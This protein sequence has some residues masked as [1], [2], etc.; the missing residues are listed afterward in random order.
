MKLESNIQYLKGVGEKR[1]ALYNKLGIVTV[2]DLLYHFP[3]NY[4][5]LST[6]YSIMSAPLD[7]TCAIIARLI[8]KST[9]KRIRKGLS[10]FKLMAEDYSGSLEITVFNAKYT[11]DSLETDKE[12]IFFGRV[13][14]NMIKR[15]MSA[16]DIYSV[17]DENT[18]L[19]IYS[20]TLGLTSKLI[21][22]NI[23]QALEDLS[24]VKDSLCD[25]ILEKYS[26]LGLSVSLR[27]I[28][29]PEKIEQAHTARERF[30]FE[31]LLVLCCGLAMLSAE[32]NACITKPMKE[33]S[34]E[35]FW[36]NLPFAPTNAQINAVNDAI[37]DMCKATPMNRLVQG[38]VGSGKTLVAA[39]CVYFSY[40]NGVQSAMMAPTSI[41][42]EQ[43]FRTIS[44][45]LSPLGLTTG[46][47]TGSTCAVTQPGTD[48]LSTVSCNKKRIYDGISNGSINFCVGTHALI[49]DGVGFSQLGFIV[50]DEQHRFGV[51]QRT[52]LQKKGRDSHVMVMSATPIPRTLSLIVYGDL[53]LSVIDEMPPGRQEIDTFVISSAKRVRAMGFL[54]NALDEGRQAYIICPLVEMGEVDT[55][56]RP[57]KEY[58]EYL[59]EN[60]FKGYSISLLHGKMNPREKEEVMRKFSNG[61]VQALVS[62]T[63]VEVGVDVPNAT[64]IL[65]EN[66]ERFGLSQLHQ[67]RGRVGRG[68]EKS[69][70]I[71]VSDAKGET[72]RGRL[73]MMKSST[74]GFEL[75]EYDLKAR[76]P[77]DFFGHRQHGLPELKVASLADNMKTMALARECAEDILSADPDLS[78]YDYSPL[79]TMVRRMMDS[80]GERPN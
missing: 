16:P 30:V 40:L 46:L 73:N 13:T 72:A 61:E 14:G 38:D 15:T 26:L 25:D 42:A 56:L 50:T 18:I 41:L 3:R 12:Y 80:V 57:A 51:T 6:P 1:A 8:H 24:D 7:E 67:L 54:R 76:G 71:L 2:R 10:V 27:Q 63:V 28:H 44:N 32:N 17:S 74:D 79:G 22:R 70:C 11:V 29:F 59:S 52:N 68:S 4:I 37:S 45:L 39:A 33:K 36:Q 75:A 19:P 60:D 53:S 31:E 48:G 58:Y 49:S 69:Y 78:S 20:Q 34:L 21:R 65:I 23:L 62:T 47:L 5:D 55:G 43:H 35:T 66:A 9:E 77:G 64:V